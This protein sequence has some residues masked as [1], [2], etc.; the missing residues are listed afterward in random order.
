MS[1]TRQFV[2][3]LLCLFSITSAV[4]CGLEDKPDPS[5]CEQMHEEC[6]QFELSFGA[7]DAV[8]TS[9]NLQGALA[10]TVRG[11]I[12]YD[13]HVGLFGPKDGAEAAA[14]FT[15]DI[16]VRER[17]DGPFLVE[18]EFPYDEYQVLGYLDSDDNYDPDDPGPDHRDPI[19]IPGDAL[20]LDRPVRS[21][22]VM[23]R[24]LL[25]TR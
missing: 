25:P 20:T 2:L 8:R 15:F 10:G 5:I 7:V 1:C 24:M 16:D 12:Y 17:R 6:G 23:F 21:F 3:S 19:M 11:E 14:K 4:S 9:S 18:T 22:D 13:E